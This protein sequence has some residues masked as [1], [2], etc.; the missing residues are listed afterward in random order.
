MIKSAVDH[1][2]SRLSCSLQVLIERRLFLL[3]LFI[4]FF[5]DEGGELDSKLFFVH[6]MQGYKYIRPEQLRI[7][8]QPIVKMKDTTGHR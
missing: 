2:F 1:F 3:I 8:H 4:I 7:G 5:T 6:C